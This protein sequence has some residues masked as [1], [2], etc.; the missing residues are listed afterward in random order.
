[1][2]DPAYKRCAKCGETKPL[3]EFH[4]WS[5]AP[6]GRKTRCKP[7]CC[8]DTKA[9]ADANP[10]K[11]SAASKRHHAAN[12]EQANAKRKKWYED[13]KEHAREQGRR[14]REDPENRKRRAAIRREWRHEKG[15]T[16]KDTERQR[17]RHPHKTRA[18]KAL[19]S[20]V[21]RGSIAKP[22][23]CERCGERTEP[24]DLHGHHEDYGKPLDVDWLC[25]QCHAKRHREMAAEDADAMP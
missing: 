9:W 12:K 7:C 21:A 6:D 19:A 8:A 24:I 16:S 4:R 13:H 17:K 3:D 18:R 15:R 14:Y 11:V 2:P 10:E 23:L 20:A 22:I 1:M 25:R 5:C